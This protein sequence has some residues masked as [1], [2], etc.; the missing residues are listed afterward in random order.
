LLFARPESVLDEKLRMTATAD[1]EEI[2]E[3]EEVL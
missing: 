3:T 1:I 2:R